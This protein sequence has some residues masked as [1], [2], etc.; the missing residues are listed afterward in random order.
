MILEDDVDWDDR[1]RTQLGLFAF[2]AHTLPSLI[3]HNIQEIQ[4]SATESRNQDP[5]DLAKRSTVALSYRDLYIPSNPY[6]ANWDV[7]W[8]GHC[9]T[10]L[11]P[12]SLTHPDRLMY[13]HDITAPAPKHLRLRESAPLD[14]IATLYPPHTR[15][16]HRTGNS[17]LCTLAYAVTQRGA[18]KILYELGVKDLSDGFDFEL[19][20][21][22]GGSDVGKRRDGDE[23]IS[24]EKRLECMTVQPPLFSHYWG[25][26]GQ[27]DIMGVGS[28]G[29][30]EV[31]SR[32]VMRSVRGSLEEQVEGTGKFFEQWSHDGSN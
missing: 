17:T 20:K 14:P 32:Y 2:A 10:S 4:P 25:A 9:G 1:L 8:L 6:N 18:R 16:Y 26:K 7:L 19:G 28:R 15:V 12:P 13:L 30:P 11:P 27:S 29:R 24:S 3:N 31:G 22:C 21:W 23:G 5:I